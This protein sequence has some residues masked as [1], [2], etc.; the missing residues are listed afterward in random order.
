MSDL[1]LRDH[2]IKNLKLAYPVMLSQLGHIMVG[3]ADSVMVGR[4]G[5]EPLAAAAFGNSIWIVIFVVG[6]G[7]SQAV[8]PI[9]A[10]AHA[11]KQFRMIGSMLR[12][13][14]AL[15][16]I[17]TVILGALMFAAWP[18][19]GSLD[20]EPQVMKLAYPYLSIITWSF[21]PLMIFQAFRQFME[22]LSHTFQPMLI[23]LSANFLNVGLNW[24]LIYGN[25]GFPEL[26]LNGAGIATLISRSLMVVGIGYYLWK[27]NLFRPFRPYFFAMPWRRDFFGRLL[28]LGIPTSLQMLFEVGAFVI[29][30]IWI[31]QISAEA[32]A[33]HQI[34]LNLA[35]IS[36]MLASG[37]AA[38][39][40]I[41]VG[42]Q[43]GL[44]DRHNLRN[45]AFSAL[46]LATLFMGT[47]G[48]LFATAGEPLARLYIDELPVI[49]SASAL[50][51]IAA[52]FQLSDG[53]Q[54]VTLG[55]LRGL[56]DVRI[57]TVITLFAYWIIGIPLG[58]YLAFSEGLNEQGIWYGL[59]A[60]LTVSAVLLFMR[61][62]RLSTRMTL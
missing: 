59:A 36:F 60:G 32:L 40:T 21:L 56:E 20:Q 23:S 58:Y 5:T 33:A 45:A 9:I 49:E 13:T 55:A 2:I 35:S 53:A 34:A 28:Q 42:N 46:I 6:Y 15:N 51:L 7:I 48:I 37:M 14:L 10:R 24:L 61:F 41:R 39:A 44:K 19:L 30:A 22:G 38:A 4:L 25:W 29:A 52:I 57:P 27:S 1:T 50:L 17:V 31:G 11:E 62:Q 43:R 12:H 26:G 47:A 54:V 8:T 3:V 18:F 16:L